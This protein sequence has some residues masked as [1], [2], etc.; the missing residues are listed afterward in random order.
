MPDLVK[1]VIGLVAVLVGVGIATGAVGLA[2]NPVV[3][4]MVVAGFAGLAY[5]V[6]QGDEFSVSFGLTVGAALVVLFQLAPD[7]ISSRLPF[8]PAI[9]G[10]DAITVVVIVGMV[11]LF[12][13]VLDIRFIS[14]TAKNPDTVAK[15][16]NKRFVK[17]IETYATVGRVAFI[18]GITAGVAILGQAGVGLGEVG[19]IVADV[20]WIAANIATAG[21]GYLS[22]GGSL[23]V[24]GSLNANV[25][26][27]LFGGLAV[28]LILAAAAADYA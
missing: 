24:I 17:L 15:K 8:A 4:G 7:V 3:A 20:P 26:P 10:L 22:L 14:Q 1:S 25:T 2:V 23:P 18:A 9:E 16:V 21:L 28:I 19:A 6:A 27:A 12:W 5:G 13:W 11:V